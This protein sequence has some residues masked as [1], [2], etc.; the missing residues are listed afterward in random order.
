MADVVLEE[1]VISDAEIVK[2]SA[3]FFEGYVRESKEERRP[4]LLY[5]DALPVLNSVAS[6]MR[7]LFEREYSNGSKPPE[8]IV[9]V[10]DSYRRD[11]KH[12]SYPINVGY[13]L[14]RH[15]TE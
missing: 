15:W 13:F 11:R 1:R 12:T 4:V 10:N 14:K 3:D 2:A 6:R 5:G 7:K 8:V 9:C